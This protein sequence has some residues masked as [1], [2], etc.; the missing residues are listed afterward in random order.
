MNRP[1][2]RHFGAVAWEALSM[3]ALVGGPFPVPVR[4]VPTAPARRTAITSPTPRA[5]ARG[6]QPAG[7]PTTKREPA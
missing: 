5:A 6:P 4:P 1:T 3:L 2:L 7:N